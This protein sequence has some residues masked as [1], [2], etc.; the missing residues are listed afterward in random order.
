MAHVQTSYLGL[1]K[2]QDLLLDKISSQKMF[3]DNIEIL[4]AFGMAVLKNT[5]APV[6]TLDALRAINTSDTMI[7]QDCKTIMVKSHGIFFFDRGNTSSDNNKTIIAPTVGGGRWVSLSVFG[8]DYDSMTHIGNVPN[9]ATNDQTP[10]YTQSNTL[11]NL[12]SG[13]KLSTSFGK[14]MKAIADLI[15]H[16]SNKTNPHGVTKAQLG[17]GNIDNTSDANKPVST[18]QA[19]AIADAKNAGTNAQTNLTA[20]TNNKS[21]PHEVIKAQLGLD[22]VPTV[23][24]NDQVP[25]YAQASTLTN[26]VSGE[27]L[28]TSFGKIMKAIADLISHLA[29]KANPH[30]VTKT[31]LGLGNVD[32][33]SDANKPIST[34]Q[35]SVNASMQQATTTIQQALNSHTGNKSNP[36]GTTAAQVGAIPVGF[37]ASSTS[38]NEDDLDAILSTAI[39]AMPDN[40]TRMIRVNFSMQHEHFVQGITAAI[41]VFKGAGSNGCAI[42]HTF[43]KGY[44][45]ILIKGLSVGEWGTWRNATSATANTMATAEVI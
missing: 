18:A 11:T 19:T 28:S 36:H 20:H 16:I 30:E 41:V 14:I 22:N 26:L 45:E 1:W 39:N 44:P 24:T 40:S 10:T 12:V 21:N 17:I 9:V 37:S 6:A 15:S 13:E 32:N 31:Q 27:K 38:T 5:G 33:T 29:N 2:P 25:T 7:Y 8:T 43:S 23:A 3:I 35:A 34:A 42:A 4:E